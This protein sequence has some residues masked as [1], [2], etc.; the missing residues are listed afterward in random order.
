MSDLFSLEFVVKATKAEIKSTS[1]DQVEFQRIE[2]DTRQ[3]LVGSL[4][5]AL[6]GAQFD[7]HDFVDQ[8][9]KKGAFGVLI[10]E[11]RPE[12]EA[13]QNQIPLLLVKDTLI[14]LQ[15]L[16]RAW[17]DKCRFKV[18]G[19]TGSNGKTSTKELAFQL[20]HP[21]LKTFASPGSFN[22]HWGV[23]LSL[24]KAT[25]KTE[26]VIQ[27]MGMNHK[28]EIR[29][30]CLM[31]RPDV[32]LVTNVG[33][34]H[35]G[36]LGS[37]AAI[38]EAKNEIYQ[39]TPKAIHIYNLDN[40]HTLDLYQQALS[41]GFPRERLLTFSSFNPKADIFLRADRV[42]V[43]GLKISGRLFKQEGKGSVQA[44]G[45]QTVSNLMGACAV[46]LALGVKPE[47]IFARFDKINLESWGRNQWIRGE[48]KPAILFDGY[49]ANPDSMKMLL[50]NL[51][52]LE[53]P[54]QKAFVFGDMK[55]LGE[56][57]EKAHQE[58]AELAAQVGLSAI[59]YMGAYGEAVNLALKKARFP[60]HLVISKDFD[61]SQA[62]P[63][64]RQLGPEDVVA[65]KAS[66]G[67]RIERLLK[68]WEIEG[69]E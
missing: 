7:G 62:Q 35:I 11:W 6:K 64:Y 34:A 33:S 61:E 16:A 28:G 8:A 19:I 42:G 9:V 60:G 56:D 47:E 49:N 55:E 59:W 15:L 48:G 43:E 66:R 1:G 45:R 21:H 18:A 41:A 63:F 38:K 12:Y 53:I 23:P 50:K 44:F 3:D 24:L 26:V 20:I 68:A 14:A 58:V 22:N 40:E 5:V 27:E 32:V 39:S 31:A 65:L 57:S 4:F 36:E 29:D 37:I 13:F 52:E 25:P 69:F 30:L 46:A 67:S 10:H 2:T 54:G 51:Y 17:R